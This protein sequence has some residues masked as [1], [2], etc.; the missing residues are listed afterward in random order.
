M[1][2]GTLFARTSKS[3][4]VVAILYFVLKR[5]QREWCDRTFL[6]DL[7][8]GMTWQ[9]DAADDASPNENRSDGSSEARAG[10][11]QTHGDGG[12]RR[13]NSNHKMFRN[14]PEVLISVLAKS[15]AA[16]FASN[17]MYKFLY[18]GPTRWRKKVLAQLFTVHARIANAHSRA[19]FFVDP[20]KRIGDAVQQTSATQYST[21]EKR[22][23]SP[24][25]FASVFEAHAPQPG[26]IDVINAGGLSTFVELGVNS[27]LRSYAV[28]QWLNELRWSVAPRSEYYC[29]DHLFVPLK[30]QCTGI[31][32][33]MLEEISKTA[34]PLMVTV[35]DSEAVDF[36]FMQDFELLCKKTYRDPPL[37]VNDDH[38]KQSDKDDLGPFDNLEFTV[39]IMWRERTEV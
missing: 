31:G 27:F 29:I 35:T 12:N 36:F 11:R 23:P 15:Y 7:L 3:L 33:V 2:G 37:N 4:A 17:P 13:Q 18:R 32:S 34:D 9:A 39:W 20:Q 6:A 5:V 24:T 22:A 38:G 26:L 28:E 21:A 16:A 25:C 19:R 30:L 8:V 1:A 14:L 10:S